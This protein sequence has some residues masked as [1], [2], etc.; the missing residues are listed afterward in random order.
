MINDILDS[1]TLF[2][3]NILV[4]MSADLIC[5]KPALSHYIDNVFMCQ[6]SDVVSAGRRHLFRVG[7]DAFKQPGRPRN[8]LQTAVR[9]SSGTG[10]G[11]E[12]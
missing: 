2:V 6:Q 3:W 4:N 1:R 12:P 5:F 11:A 9:T 7:D 10:A 8:M